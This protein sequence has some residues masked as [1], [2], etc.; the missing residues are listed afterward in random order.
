MPTPSG[1]PTSQDL[2]NAQK[3]VE[4]LGRV[5]NSED[6][7]GNPI[8]S[9]TNRTGGTNK[10]LDALQTEYQSAIQAA[11]GVPLGTWSS[12]ITYN[13]Y[14]EYLVYNGIPYKPAPTTPLPYT[15]QGSDPTVAPD[16]GNVVPFAEVQAS[17]L[18]TVRE[19]L[20]GPG[21]QLYM[22]DD[23][24][25]VKVGDTVPA[26]TTHLR[27]EVGGNPTL[28]AM[29]PVASGSVTVLG[30][31][32]AT[33]GG[34][35]ISYDYG[36]P[37]SAFVYNDANADTINTQLF[38]S[39]VNSGREILIQGDVFF[40]VNSLLA[41]KSV[42]VTSENDALITFTSS[43]T[44]IRLKDH[45]SLHADGCR[46]KAES[47]DVVKVLDYES[48]DGKLNTVKYTNFDIIGSVQ[49]INP[50]TNNNLNPEDVDFGVDYVSIEAG[51]TTG[52]TEPI[53]RMMSTPYKKVSVKS[54]HGVNDKGVMT[55]FPVSDS[56]PYYFE[57]QKSMI[58]LTVDNLSVTNDR[59]IFAQTP[60]QFYA[61]IVLWEG[62]DA[63]VDNTVCTGV[64]TSDGTP[65]YD[66]Y[67]AGINSS[68]VNCQVI[69]SWAFG[70]DSNT[71][72]KVKKAKKLRA[73][74]KNTA[75]SD[76]FFE[77]HENTHG[78]L[79]ANSSGNP[80]TLDLQVDGDDYSID[81]CTLITPR[82][83]TDGKNKAPQ[84][85]KN[86]TLTNSRI[87]VNGGTG[88]PYLAVSK[89]GPDS[90]ESKSCVITNNNIVINSDDKFYLAKMTIDNGTPNG[91]FIDM[92]GND[93]RSK[94]GV[95]ELL[96]TTT[97]QNNRDTSLDFIRV[98]N[99]VYT[100]GE[101]Q[102]LKNFC[103]QTYVKNTNYDGSVVQ[104]NSDTDQFVFF[105]TNPMGDN[106]SSGSYRFAKTAPQQKVYTIAFHRPQSSQVQASNYFIKGDIQ[107]GSNFKQFA[108][109]FFINPNLT[110]NTID[111]TVPVLG[112][113]TQTYTW[114]GN[115][116]NEIPIDIGLPTDESFVMR[117]ERRDDWVGFYL[118]FKSGEVPTHAALS[119]EY[120]SV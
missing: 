38:V 103:K 35:S 118:G 31:T 86:F 40:A 14:N 99:R 69:D 73:Y 111:I 6:A 10:T 94:G 28:V 84:P 59:G 115:N 33:I 34:V 15:T 104:I 89:W 54:V 65:V 82:C 45:L 78:L 79:L 30:D 61:G 44:F 92:S 46:F 87:F 100:D 43:G 70:Y 3:D 8:A 37:F 107:Y 57:C 108:T 105:G 67:M 24:E 96:M 53:V 71:P 17:D 11:G 29:S 102:Q 85:I 97:D 77:Y 41:E 2:I 20:L 49:L 113:G 98:S 80:Y 42:K 4:H 21:T 88:S 32:G 1:F 39:A 75:F 63:T 56:H 112:G 93:L 27:V 101:Y 58:D 110:A 116:S 109:S 25:S 13:A 55:T 76:D 48:P 19:D 47:G 68:T 120:I 90:G 51:S 106:A 66:F 81:N 74:G 91:G 95:N 26:G 114:N 119:W 117:V 36:G 60:T 72:L 83:D 64:V 9:S 18:V 22:G 7:Q 50:S 16:A 52:R 12:G 62:R 23:G 5:V